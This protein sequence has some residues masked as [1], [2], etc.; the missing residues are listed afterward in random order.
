MLNNQS[1]FNLIELNYFS[2]FFFNVY[3]EKELLFLLLFEAIN[4]WKEREI[5]FKLVVYFLCNL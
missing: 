2:S 5:A 1:L 3:F 4:Y